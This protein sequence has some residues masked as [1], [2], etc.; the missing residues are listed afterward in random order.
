MINELAY[1]DNVL[2]DFFTFGI[3]N[4]KKIATSWQKRL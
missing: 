3:L 2:T 1:H 4:L